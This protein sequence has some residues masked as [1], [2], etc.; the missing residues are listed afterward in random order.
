M[1]AFDLSALVRYITRFTEESFAA[2]ISIIFIKEAVAKLLDITKEAPVNMNPDVSPFHDCYC[3]APKEVV[4]KPLVNNTGTNTTAGNTTTMSTATVTAVYNVTTTEK[5]WHKIPRADC[6]EHGGTLIGDGCQ[7][8]A[9][10]FFLSCLLF[11]FTFVIAYAL[12]NIKTTRF[13]PTWVCS[14]HKYSRHSIS[15]SQWDFFLQ[16]QITR[17]AN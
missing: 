11:I 4:V 15:R 10:V 3:I 16:V 5:H 14:S 1:V 17:S 2:L 8:V 13:F 6:L 9:D 7:H 12:K